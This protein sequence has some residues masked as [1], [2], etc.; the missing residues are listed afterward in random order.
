MELLKI[1]STIFQWRKKFCCFIFYFNAAK[2][3][4]DYFSI[5]KITLFDTYLLYNCQNMF[6]LF[7]GWSEAL[8]SEALYPFGKLCIEINCICKFGWKL[9]AEKNR[10]VDVV[11]GRKKKV[12]LLLKFKTVN[13]NISLIYNELVW[14][15]HWR[16]LAFCYRS[17]FPRSHSAC[18]PPYN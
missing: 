4:M 13:S 11:N 7:Y 12:V 18:M 9:K 5:H 17:N 1:M 6:G 16:R 8:G 3:W 15:A 10:I 2:M 14:D